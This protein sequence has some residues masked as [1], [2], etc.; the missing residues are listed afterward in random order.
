MDYNNI[1][2][3][4]LHESVLVVRMRLIVLSV[5]FFGLAASFT[6]V[7][8]QNPLL[9]DPNQTPASEV[10]VATPIDTLSPVP[11]IITPTEII[12]ATL[13]PPAVPQ[14]ST[15]IVLETLSPTPNETPTDLP[16]DMSTDEVINTP[17]ATDTNIP[18]ATASDIPTITSSATLTNVP[19][20]TASNTPTALPVATFTSIPTVT[21]SATPAALAGA[22]ATLML[23]AAAP[24]VDTLTLS[25]TPTPVSEQSVTLTAAADSYVS[26]SSPGINFGVSTTLRTDGSPI[27]RSYLRFDVPA[28]SAISKATL[29]I[30][31]NSA[32][33]V[34]YTVHLTTGDWGETTINFTNA[35]AYSNGVGSSGAITAN[36][37]TQVDVTTLV[38]GA[39]QYNFVI[40]TTSNTAT[41]F[42]SREGANSP[43]LIVITG[44]SIIVTATATP[45]DLPTLTSTPTSSFTPTAAETPTPTSTATPTAELSPTAT[46]TT[47]ATLTNTLTLSPTPTTVSSPTPTLSPTPTPVSEQTVTLTAAADSYVSYSSPGINFGVSTTLRTDASPIQRSYLRFDVPALSAISKATLQIYA[48]SAVS[49]GYT[50]HLTTG[51]WGETTLTYSNA[52]AYGNGVGNSGAITANSW[53]QV[54]VTALV[55]G[56]GQYNFVID[57]TSNTAT[58]FSSR[59]GANPPRLIVITGGSIIVTATA[60][61]TRVPTVVLSPTPTRTPT[62]TATATLTNT[63]IPTNTPVPT[64]TASPTPISTGSD[65]IVFAASDI[66]CDSLNTT[67]I[68]C[69]QMAASQIVVDQKPNAVLLVGDLCHTPSVN[70]FDNYY[71]P[72]WGRLFP[73]TFPVTGN[74]EYKVAGAVYYFDYWN[75]V[76]NANGPAG[77]RSQGYYSFDIGTWHIIA[78]NSQCSSAGGCGSTSPQYT[79]LKQD[80]TDHR[81]Y[82]TLAYYHIPVFSSGG[83]AATNMVQIFTLL[84][85]NNVDIVLDGH[86]HI[87]ERFAPQNPSG[88]ADTLRGVREFIVGTGGANHT[89]IVV[90]QPNSEVRN[91]DTFG[92][93]KLTLHSGSYDWQFVPIAGKTFTDAGSNTCH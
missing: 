29:Q 93:L 66:I 27:Q 4:L 55:T 60:T 40:D 20:V 64:L 32:V 3:L 90:V 44:G 77:N 59:E 25:P 47:T 18:L 73:I 12:A 76:G 41:S 7:P 85:N 23:T 54:D 5:M 87:Y 69:Q 8:S 19:T 78:L 15:E 1:S 46:N 70:C 82:C 80:L 30:Y 51:D 91:V 6:A 67:S 10:N 35:P 65:P 84:Y 14:A 92:A 83:R 24:L 56:A 38:T 21:A 42:S 16:T 72:S 28:L 81:N 89:S 11:T 63:F 57:T 33:S 74:H 53:T 62:L 52:P 9:D 45:T 50:V 71:N 36:S 48:N 88:Q 75:G 49:V 26:Y 68:G 79:W 43:R 17:T 34:G 37:W 61:P 2:Y 13:P 22:A 86:D 39:G 31:A 58:S